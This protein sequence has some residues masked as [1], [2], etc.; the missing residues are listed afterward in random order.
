MTQ[1]TYDFLEAREDFLTSNLRYFSL[2][3][4][5]DEALTIVSD[6]DGNGLDGRGKLAT[7]EVSGDSGILHTPL[8]FKPSANYL[9]DIEAKVS[10]GDVSK[11]KL[12]VGL[13]QLTIV[14]DSVV[15]DIASAT[16]TALTKTASHYAGFLYSEG[17]TDR[18]PRIVYRG[19]TV[20][21]STVFKQKASGAAPDESAVETPLADSGLVILRL[22]AD[23]EGGVEFWAR[24]R[25]SMLDGLGGT[26]YLPVESYKRI[27]GAIDPDKVYMACIGVQA[28]TAVLAAA[29]LGYTHMM[30]KQPS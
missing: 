15:D 11:D 18:L 6:T 13:A 22:R 14:A 23:Q 25:Q 1:S 12:F 30:W 3:G 16:A 26:V 27:P 8:M 2:A 21:Q 24:G 7:G 20:E 28:T 19:G 4:K 17:F 5:G 10:V 29:Y 9:V